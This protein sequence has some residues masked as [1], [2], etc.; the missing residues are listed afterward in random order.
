M[1]GSKEMVSSALSSPP[2]DSHCTNWTSSRRSETERREA[3]QP[4]ECSWRNWRLSM[5]ALPLTELR[6]ITFQ[7]RQFGRRTEP[8]KNRRTSESSILKNGKQ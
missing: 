2:P 3:C 1:A 6:N 7:N 8:Q 4:V 5:A